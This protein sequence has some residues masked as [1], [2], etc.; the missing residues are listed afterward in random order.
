MSELPSIHN[1]LKV[2]GLS[3]SIESI[4]NIEDYN[5]HSS[6][7]EDEDNH[8][9][10]ALE[11]TPRRRQSDEDIDYLSMTHLE[12]AFNTSL[13]LNESIDEGTENTSIRPSFDESFDQEGPMRLED[14]DHYVDKHQKGF[15]NKLK[16]KTPFDSHKSQDNHFTVSIKTDYGSENDC[17]I[18]SPRSSRSSRSS[19]SP[20]GSSSRRSIQIGSNWSIA[21]QCLKQSAS[22][23]E[24]IG[25]LRHICVL[26]D[27][28]DYADRIRYCKRDFENAVKEIRTGTFAKTVICSELLREVSYM[29]NKY[30]DQ[31]L[32]NTLPEEVIFEIF[33]YL[34]VDDFS[35]FTATCREWQSLSASD[36]IW[37][38]LYT[39][40]FLRSNPDG[41]Q[42]LEKCEYK[43]KYCSRLNDPELG[44]KVEVAWKGK[45]RLEAN[46]VYQ[47][48]AWWCAEIVDKHTEQGKYKIRYP[49]WEPRWDEWVPRHK[50]R[51][52][53]ER[54]DR[55][56]IHA[57][58]IVELWCVGANVPG[59]W[60]ESK[61]KKVKGDRY[62]I[63]RVLTSGN[64]SHSRPK[65][66]ERGDLRLVRHPHDEEHLSTLSTADGAPPSPSRM[67]QFLGLIGLNRWLNSNQSSVVQDHVENDPHPNPMV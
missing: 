57:G 52:A 55:A 67:S 26:L 37:K 48:L 34:P 44:D 66:V 20:F 31:N 1:G 13:D 27:E 28:I 54:D 65:W 59:A 9:L 53:V 39:Y 29:M 30:F 19:Y 58:S 50:L 56:P 63:N 49:G 22:T 11:D 46:D 35:V 24:C 64:T 5:Y 40:K 8:F 6:F 51:W 2:S 42:P 10:T 3:S 45:F 33:L 41:V 7:D 36:Y 16:V 4:E 21:I 62:M 18:S 32:F 15:G 61:V 17:I 14:P 12:D 25:H 43:K 60:L 38:D 47:G 23:F